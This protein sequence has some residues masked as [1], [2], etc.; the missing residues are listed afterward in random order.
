[1]FFAK[2]VSEVKSDGGSQNKKPV[3]H[4]AH[5]SKNILQYTIIITSAP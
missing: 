2:I 4:I 5:L 1:M 3:V